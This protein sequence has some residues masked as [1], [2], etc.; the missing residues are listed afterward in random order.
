MIEII[1]RRPSGIGRPMQNPAVLGRVR[2]A[3]G[4]PATASA[5]CQ[6]CGERSRYSRHRIWTERNPQARCASNLNV[7]HTA[8]TRGLFAAHVQ[9]AFENLIDRFAA[10]NRTAGASRDRQNTLRLAGSRPNAPSLR[11]AGYSAAAIGMRAVAK[12]QAK[13]DAGHLAR[14]RCNDRGRTA[15]Q[16]V[17][18]RHQQPRRAL[19][20]RR[21]HPANSTMPKVSKA[22]VLRSTGLPPLTAPITS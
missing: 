14:G 18:G 22:N 17:D 4:A 11:S 10:Q 13:C 12:M 3:I 20:R 5:C 9:A 15:R 7:R 21:R 19:N 6:Y 1:E 2:D 8:S 16:L